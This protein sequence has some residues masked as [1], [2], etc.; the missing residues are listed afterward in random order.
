MSSPVFIDP[1]SHPSASSYY[2]L[3]PIEP[4]AEGGFLQIGTVT[5]INMLS[6]ET[7]C[8]EILQKFK[9]TQALVIVS[10][11]NDMGLALRLSRRSTAGL[12]RLVGL[13]VLVNLIKGKITSD[14]AKKILRFKSDQSFSRFFNRLSQF[15]QKQ[16]DRVELRACDTGSNLSTMRSLKT[17]FGCKKITAPKILNV[18]GTINPGSPTNSERKWSN[19]KRNNPKAAIEIHGTA[20]HRFGTA[21]RM[22]GAQLQIKAITESWPAAQLW[23]SSK[24]VPGNYKNGP[25]PYQG[26]LPSMQSN[27]IVFSGEKRFSSL[28]T[29]VE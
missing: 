19:F 21:I 23:A 11:G 18:F 8:T 28:L 13:D 1:S 5:T 7:I 3:F 25:L 15:R 2:R 26:L 29:K 14:E 17:V 27:D 24:L 10:H 4:L 20:P 16:I 9:E 12:Q 6:L 22:F